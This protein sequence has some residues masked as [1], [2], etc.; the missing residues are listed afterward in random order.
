M[1]LG[2]LMGYGGAFCGIMR[3]WRGIL[4][5]NYGEVEGQLGNYENLCGNNFIVKLRFLR[6]VIRERR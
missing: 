6:F 2:E 1:S 5:K 3:Q 4:V